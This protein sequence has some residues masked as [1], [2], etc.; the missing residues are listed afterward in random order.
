MNMTKVQQAFFALVRAGL[1]GEDVKLSH[2]GVVD[3]SEVQRLADEQ[4]LVGLVAAGLEHV[5]DIKV[6]KDDVLQFVGQALL[7]EQQNKAM[8]YFIGVLEDNMKKEGIHA[9]LVKGQAVAQCYEKPAWR[10]SG[11]VDLLLDQENYERAK[12]YLT[13]IADDI[14]EENPFD[15]HFSV[16][17]EGWC[18]ELHG[19]MRSMLTK[20][21]DDY[22]EAFQVELFKEG[23]S[24]VWNNDGIQVLLPNPDDD[25]IFVFT[26]ILKH[27]FNYGIGLR[28]FC[29]L[30]RLTYTY[31]EELDLHLLESRLR[32]MGL[33]TEWKV[34]G[35]LAVNW[36]GM[37]E[38]AMPFYTPGASW[39]RK[40]NR[41]VSFVLDTGKCGQNRDNEYYQNSSALLR[42]IRSF[43]RHTCDSVRQAFIFPLDSVKIWFRVLY[44]GISDAIKGK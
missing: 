8:N 22:L 5:S 26:H 12:E 4:A 6:P 27:F 15:K 31:H 42:G 28:Q 16:D 21:A 38:D 20:R 34:F 37:P 30:C 2:L 14:H 25:I 7:L 1:W 29:D 35:A 13:S 43:W 40:A 41:V 32:S 36:L 23:R 11:D 3:F 9:L 44:I 33:M 39:K 19:T 24:R 17:I 18:V 10:V